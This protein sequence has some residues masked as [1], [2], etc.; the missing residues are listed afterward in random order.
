MLST[1]S[2]GFQYWLAAGCIAGRLLDLSHT[3]VVF[4]LLGSNMLK[5]W[6]DRRLYRDALKEFVNVIWDVNPFVQIFLGSVIPRPGASP[7]TLLKVKHFNW[8]ARTI[9]K[10]LS[11][12]GKTVR[13]V[14]IHSLFLNEDFT[15]KD[16]KR[17]FAPDQFHISNYAAYFVRRMFLETAHLLPQTLEE[18]SSV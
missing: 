15:F 17:W 18:T 11:S 1:S 5:T 2:A 7:E 14:P 9:A 13:T 4:S 6:I 8:E 16:V 10:K 3:T 12:Q